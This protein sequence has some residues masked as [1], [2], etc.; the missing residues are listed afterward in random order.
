MIR[1]VR[2]EGVREPCGPDPRIDD[3]L[4]KPG[5]VIFNCRASFGVKICGEH[6]RKEDCSLYQFSRLRLPMQTSLQ[7][8]KPI[9]TSV[10][11][12]LRR[13]SEGSRFSS[14]IMITACARHL[15]PS[16]D[17]GQIRKIR[18]KLSDC[19]GSAAQQV[20]DQDHKRN[21]KQ[22]M[23]QASRNV[24]AETQK[25]QNQKHHKN[26]P[27]HISLL[28]QDV[29]LCTSRVPNTEPHCSI[30][31]KLVA[32]GRRRVARKRKPHK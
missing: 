13:L 29:A 15:E 8:G 7:L 18:L 3:D 32:P 4:V 12:Q 17:A 26:R 27:K 19:A 20:D 2:R 30:P 10:P 23:D 22:Q 24:Q 16:D 11:R 14:L 6:L 5:N 31:V 1:A 28:R 21:H 25:P 9:L